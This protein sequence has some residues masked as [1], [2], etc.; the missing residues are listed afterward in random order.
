M[1]NSRSSESIKAVESLI[2]SAVS[3]C[4]NC[5]I[6]HSMKNNTSD[7]SEIAL[8]HLLSFLVMIYWCSGL[9]LYLILNVTLKTLM[10]HDLIKMLYS[11]LGVMLYFDP[12]RYTMNDT[13]YAL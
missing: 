3:L 1:V 5:A 11:F 4:E 8:C 10:C 13:H 7:T 12:W 9:P 2:F 6:N